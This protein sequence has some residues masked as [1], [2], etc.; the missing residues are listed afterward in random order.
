MKTLVAVMTIFFTVLTAFAEPPISFPKIPKPFQREQR[1]V[2]KQGEII[3]ERKDK[4]GITI[5]T[6]DTKKEESLKEGITYGE[7]P[8]LKPQKIHL[9]P[10]VVSEKDK[11]K[12]L[13]WTSEVS[14]LD[15]VNYA[16]RILDI[17]PNDKSALEFLAWHY[18]NN[19]NFKKAMDYF[20]KL[21]KYYPEDKNSIKGFVLTLRATGN[22]EQ[23][24]E[25][26]K[27]FNIEIDLLDL[28]REIVSKD[29]EQAKKTGDNKELK[30]F[31]QRHIEKPNRCYMADIF[32]EAAKKILPFDK[33]MGQETLFLLLNCEDI[34][35]ELRYGIV[36]E[37]SS[38]IEYEQFANLKEQQWSHFSKETLFVN[39][40][41][42]LE[43]SILQKNLSREDIDEAK[44][45]DYAQRILKLDPENLFAKEFLG[46][47]FYSNKKYPEAEEI[48][49]ELF[50]KTSEQNAL[51]GLIFTLLSQNKID[52][53]LEFSE[54]NSKILDSSIKSTVYSTS[55]GKLLDDGQREK[56]FSLMKMLSEKEDEVLK[57]IA[58]DYYCK[59]GMPV[60]ASFVSYRDEQACYSREKYMKIQIS[61]SYR[62]KKGESGLSKIKIFENRISLI[63]PF[64]N[65]NVLIFSIVGEHLN[66][67]SISEKA[68]IGRY[69]LS[70]DGKPALQT[71]I[72]SKLTLKPEITFKKDG[73][74]S[75][76]II[77]GSSP[78][79]ALYSPTP[80]IDFIIYDK[81][82]K[83]NLF[84]K[85]V[86][87]SILSYIGQKDPYTNDKWGM[88]LSTGVS[89]EYSFKLSKPLWF[90]VKA[91]YDILKGKNVINNNHFSSTISFGAYRDLDKERTVNLGLFLVFD[92]YSKNTN[93]FTYGHGGYYSPQVFLMPG[94]SFRYTEKKCCTENIDI[95]TAI[96]YIY[97]KT[98][99]SP[100]Y[101]LNGPY[102]ETQ[103]AVDDFNS[104][105]AG[106]KKGKLGGSLEAYIEKNLNFGKAVF[107][108]KGNVNRGYNEF[109]IGGS[110]FFDLF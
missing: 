78:L 97:E 93:Y 2:E 68:Q 95:K 37:L 59:E 15:K 43:I 8:K 1:G 41:E 51:R 58:S 86:N 87:D 84:R 19:K 80:V 74:P 69:Y 35:V 5:E 42:K 25:I 18:Y 75:L 39:K 63:Y 29:Y 99:D 36:A 3:I 50:N 60:T 17:A 33:K 55:I 56:A 108:F 71:P 34:P 90:T 65:S 30:K 49:R 92:H 77:L 24:L 44:K 53:A 6:K 45:F 88:V 21:F 94:I 105:Y 96:G 40:L 64:P 82:W 61:P 54:K 62:Y 104:N 11:L 26:A 76:V 12:R 20:E 27:K 73:I 52:E 101:P 106:S 79:N 10:D 32:F 14:E 22:P 16:N 103:P 38:Y 67:G 98:K 83:I 70:L 9:K 48:F 13:L 107:F 7:I 31:I 4:T 57:K 28:E 110:L 81:D 109:L 102:P 85:Q 47:H 91:Q 100:K 89:G 46:W 72:D 23:A 66:S